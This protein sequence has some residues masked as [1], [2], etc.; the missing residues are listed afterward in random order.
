MLSVNLLCTPN[1]YSPISIIPLELGQSIISRQLVKSVGFFLFFF[2]CGPEPFWA[3]LSARCQKKIF[4]EISE[5]ISQD[6]VN[7]RP[8]DWAVPP[9]VVY[10]ARAS[11]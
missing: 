10:F 9:R 4:F 11:G 3:S 6:R 2:G 8:R 7:L 1:V 5:E